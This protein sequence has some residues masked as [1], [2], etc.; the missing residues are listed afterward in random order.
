[1]SLPSSGAPQRGAGPRR[2]PVIVSAEADADAR[3]AALELAA[4]G[5]ALGDAFEDE[6]ASALATLADVADSAQ[7]VTGSIGRVRVGSFAWA[8]VYAVESKR[9]VVA[10]LVRVRPKTKP[11]A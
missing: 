3:A 8:A 10:A 4:Q 9:V 11:S 6:L 1:V 5:G 2:K 7:Q